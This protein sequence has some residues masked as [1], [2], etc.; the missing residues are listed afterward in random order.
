PYPRHMPVAMVL[1]LALSNVPNATFIVRQGVVE[2]TTLKAASPR[3]LLRQRVLANFKQDPLRDALDSLSAASGLNVVLD[4]RL[5]D[6]LK[7]PV[8]ATFG[9]GITLE[10]ALLLLTDMTDLKL[11]ITD[12]FVYVTTPANAR[13]MHKERREAEPQAPGK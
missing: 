11:Y 3:Q 9:N 6:K 13:Q 10:G 8:S 2:V 12:E 4:Q 1:R 5:G 7:T